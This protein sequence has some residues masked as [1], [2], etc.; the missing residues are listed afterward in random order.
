MTANS[1]WATSVAV[2]VNANGNSARIAGYR[3]LA[4][5]P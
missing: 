5:Y 4:F 3:L 1:D 2:S